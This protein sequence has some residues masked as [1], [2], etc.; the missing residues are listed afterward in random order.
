[1]TSQYPVTG[2]SRCDFAENPARHQQIGPVSDGLPCSDDATT[3]G[4][5]PG[6]LLVTYL[7]A[8][9]PQHRGYQERAMI[10]VRLSRDVHSGP[11]EGPLSSS[12]GH[13][14]RGAAASQRPPLRSL[15]GDTRRHGHRDFGEI[16]IPES[17]LRSRATLVT[18]SKVSG[19][20]AL[21]ISTSTP[22]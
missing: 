2:K 4:G 22:W 8:G 1:M 13:L 21:V 7:N 3:N 18:C 11:R 5:H 6:R 16:P 17:T 10:E 20:R 14:M 15:L 9:Y 12:L 19:G